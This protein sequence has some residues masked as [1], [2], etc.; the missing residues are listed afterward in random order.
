MRRMFRL[1]LPAALF[2]S[3]C[4][5][6]PSP[7]PISI[8]EEPVIN[9]QDTKAVPTNTIPLPTVDTSYEQ[10]K[11]LAGKW[12]GVW[13]NIT[14]GSTGTIKAVI[15]VLPDHSASFELTVTGNVLGA[16]EPPTTTYAG[17]YDEEGLHFSGTGLP[18]FGD[19]EITIYYSGEIEM[20]ARVLPVAGIATLES[21]GTV[22]GDEMTF[23]YEVEFVG[24]FKANGT[25]SMTRMP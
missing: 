19:L 11:Q 5:A 10:A 13:T 14:F 3:A 7:T 25:A 2:L 12:E 23:T 15:E 22:S 21:E 24:D 16:G 4:T 17:S 18:I 6:T 1:L 9:L 20:T 8:V